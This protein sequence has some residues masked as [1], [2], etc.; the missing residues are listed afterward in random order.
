MKRFLTIAIVI[1][2]LAA[3][4]FAYWYFMMGSP[5]PASQPTTTP[6]QSFQPLN[7]NGSVTPPGKRNGGTLSPGGNASGSTIPA[8]LPTLRLLSATPVAGYSASSTAA[9]TTIV[10]VDRGRGNV[11]EAS[12][13]AA[14]ITTL[15]NTVVPKIFNAVW[16]KN[17]TAFIGSLYEDGNLTP[18]NIYAELQKQRG[19]TASSTAMNPSL[20]PY[21]LQGKD[22]PGN[23]I[24]YAVSPDKTRLFILL[25][26]NGSGV[27]YI[28]AFNGTGMTRLFSTPMTQVS[29]DW[30]S[31]NVISI[32]TKGSKIYNGFLYFVNPKTGVWTRVLGPV[33]GL[34]AVV[35]HDGKNVIYS[36]T[37]GDTSISTAIY[38]VTAATST[39]AVIRTVAD[40][41]AWGKLYT[42]IVYCGVPSDLPS[43][44]YPDDWYYGNISFNDRIWQLNAKTGEV[45]QIA[46]ITDQS[47]RI[48]DT[49]RPDTD[50]RD[51]YL[52]FMNKTDLSFWSLDLT[53]TASNR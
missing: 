17:L 3:A 52:L 47:D 45:K 28:A 8:P 14:D 46:S 38:S 50:S 32:I 22:I 11:Y 44:A 15:S 16:N 13:A 33:T 4:G 1:L 36:S 37:D 7:P 27:G 18:T 35:S 9:T 20:T 29:V 34:S 2:V 39:D 24:G 6:G 5:K 30:P 43:A 19:V 23:V 40:K 25:N 51:K 49:Y 10:W 41:C 53:R 21:V 48:I 26:E 42:S 12:D 31:D